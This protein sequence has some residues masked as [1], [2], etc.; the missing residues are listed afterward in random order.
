M[1][2]YKHKKRLQ[3]LYLLSSS[4]EDIKLTNYLMKIF[5]RIIILYNFL[6]N[7]IIYM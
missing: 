6:Y 2:D 3:P 1:N 4:Q 5:H 7:V